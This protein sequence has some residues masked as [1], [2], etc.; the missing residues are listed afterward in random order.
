MTSIDILHYSTHHLFIIYIYIMRLLAIALLA[1]AATGVLAA[2]E[3]K[4][5]V[6]HAV[7]CERKTQNGD[8]CAFYPT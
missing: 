6:T 3:L 8:K 5:D 7:E 1:S 2:E 4:I